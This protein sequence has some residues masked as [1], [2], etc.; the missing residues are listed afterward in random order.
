MSSFSPKKILLH[1]ANSLAEQTEFNEMKQKCGLINAFK[2]LVIDHVC[3]Q[4]PYTLLPD[5]LGQFKFDREVIGIS[6]DKYSYFLQSLCC[7]QLEDDRGV[8]NAL[9]DLKLTNK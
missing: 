8:E 4:Y 5:E 3:F 1:P 2:H 7:L 9:H 6:P